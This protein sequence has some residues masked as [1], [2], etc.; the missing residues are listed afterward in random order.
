MNIIQ[1]IKTLYIFF[2]VALLG[3]G[4]TKLNQ[5]LNSTL[6]NDQASNALGA[7]GTQ[8]LLQTAYND[9]GGPYS[10]PGNIQALEEV[11]ADQ[12]VVPT[13]AGDWDD[14]GK[15]RA[16][17]QH[18]FGADGVDIILGQFNAL[19]KLNFDATNVLAF[20]PTKAQAAEAR[21][22]ARAGIVPVARS[23]WAISFS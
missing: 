14:N 23:F 11:T 7:N 4:C 5:N 1:S 13:R 2:A 22:F 21:F 9:V 12:C 15:W 18:T 16:L 17:K 8:L 20:N 6:T 3:T 10:D 19:N